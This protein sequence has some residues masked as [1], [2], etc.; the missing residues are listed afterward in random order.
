[1]LFGTASLV[2]PTLKSILFTIKLP[3]K[4]KSEPDFET[5]KGTVLSLVIP[6]IVNFPITLKP[7]ADF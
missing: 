1:M 5:F 6:F 4:V 7:S 3:E 2:F